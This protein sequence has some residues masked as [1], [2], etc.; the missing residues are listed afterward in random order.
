MRFWTPR[1]A[2][3][4]DAEFVVF[5]IHER[6]FADESREAF[7]SRNADLLGWCPSVLDR[8]QA[9]TSLPMYEDFR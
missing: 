8:Y 1:V 7:A 5:L 3:S 2:V 9:L 4:D 6:M